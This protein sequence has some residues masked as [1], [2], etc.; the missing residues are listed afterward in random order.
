MLRN[1]I[2]EIKV[3]VGFRFRKIIMLNVFRYI[4]YL[5]GVEVWYMKRKN[6]LKDKVFGIFMMI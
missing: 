6:S 4:V 3:L 2:E 1:K 5:W